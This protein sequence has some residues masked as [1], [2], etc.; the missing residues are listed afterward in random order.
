MNAKVPAKSNRWRF[1]SQ[2][3]AE[4]NHLKGFHA[5]ELTA[6][7][8]SYPGHSRV[9]QNAIYWYFCEVMHFFTSLKFN[10]FQASFPIGVKSFIND[11]RFVCFSIQK[12]EN[13]F[14]SRELMPKRWTINNKNHFF[15]GYRKFRQRWICQ[16]KCNLS[17]FLD[18]LTM[19]HIFIKIPS[20]ECVCQGDVSIVKCE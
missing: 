10:V 20:T 13:E 8:K 5:C 6:N 11:W 14:L 15:S 9:Y 3:G 19:E 1:T 4:P 2:S 17:H 16:Q 7:W 12:Y 18:I